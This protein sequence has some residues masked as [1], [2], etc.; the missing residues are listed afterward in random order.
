MLYIIIARD[1]RG[2]ISEVFHGEETDLSVSRLLAQFGICYSVNTFPS[3]CLRRLYI[4]DYHIAILNEH[5]ANEYI[6]ALYEIPFIPKRQHFPSPSCSRCY[7][8]EVRAWEIFNT[9]SLPEYILQINFYWDSKFSNYKRKMHLGLLSCK[10]S[11]RNIKPV[12]RISAS[13]SMITWF[14]KELEE[15]S[16]HKAQ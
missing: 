9:R 4:A 7:K 16:L 3:N 2:P 10:E 11:G 13:S 6:L 14:A 1:G 15:M 8:K 5:I 12:F